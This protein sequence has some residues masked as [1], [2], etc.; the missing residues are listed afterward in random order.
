MQ[1]MGPELPDAL[2]PYKEKLTPR[3]FEVRTKAIWAK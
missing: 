2:L 3:F 1:L